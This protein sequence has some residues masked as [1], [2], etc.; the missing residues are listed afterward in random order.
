MGKSSININL[1]S[2]KII[3]SEKISTNELASIDSKNIKGIV[4]AEGGST[5]HV[6]IISKAM[7][8]PAVVGI[9]S[10]ITKLKNNIKLILNGQEGEVIYNPNREQL[11]EYKIKKNIYKENF[12]K[13]IKNNKEIAK[14]ISGQVIKVNANIGSLDEVRKALKYGAD[15]IGLLRTE[16]CFLNRKKLPHRKRTI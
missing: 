7:E 9:K 3:V 12:K 2:P 16:F 6:S 8:I 10:K 5:D 4:T 14:T 11:K 13:A 1:S 15:G